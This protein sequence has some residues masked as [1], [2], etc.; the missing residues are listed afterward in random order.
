MVG[1]VY[2]FIS[3]EGSILY[4]YHGCKYGRVKIYVSAIWVMAI[5][6][7]DYLEIVSLQYGFDSYN[8]MLYNGFVVDIEDEIAKIKTPSPKPKLQ[9]Q[10]FQCTARG[11]NPGHPD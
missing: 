10:C 9:K 7:E 4:F 1:N 2:G 11:S 3:M 6:C 5:L 8:D